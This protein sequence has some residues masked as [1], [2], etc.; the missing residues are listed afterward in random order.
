MNTHKPLPVFRADFTTGSHTVRS[1]VF[2]SPSISEAIGY[3]QL[4]FG[5]SKVNNHLERI[6]KL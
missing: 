2:V 4:M 5:E 6:T 1:I 3:L